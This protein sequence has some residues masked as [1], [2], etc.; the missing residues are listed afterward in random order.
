MGQPLRGLKTADG[1]PIEV[2]R[3]VYPDP[4]NNLQGIPP[5]RSR[6]V[7]EI[8][9]DAF[10]GGIVLVHWNGTRLVA[11]KWVNPNGS[12]RTEMH[13]FDIAVQS[14]RP[15]ELLSAPDAVSRLV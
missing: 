14:M 9:P 5:G 12:W 6:K 8:K 3:L 4:R 15:S 11:I 2:G 10:P 13:D 7:V 1:Q